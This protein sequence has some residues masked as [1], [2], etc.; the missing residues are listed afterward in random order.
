LSEER[1]G[2][3]DLEEERNRAHLERRLHKL[4]EEVHSWRRGCKLRG[5]VHLENG[6]ISKEKGHTSKEE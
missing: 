1:R 3:R 2:R 5:D 6:C 4:C